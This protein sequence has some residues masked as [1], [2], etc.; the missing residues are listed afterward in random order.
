MKK[1]ACLLIFLLFAGVQVV[2]AQTTR[3]GTGIAPL[4]ILDG[5]EVDISTFDLINVSDI[6]SITALKHQTAIFTY[7]KCATH[8]AIVITT[9]KKNDTLDTLPLLRDVIFVLDGVV[10]NRETLLALNSDDLAVV[11]MIGRPGHFPFVIFSVI[12]I[13]DEYG[14]LGVAVVEAGEKTRNV[15]DI[16]KNTFLRE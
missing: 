6:K 16:I 3:I 4:F 12:S 10:T 13:Y 9:K 2:C 5:V 8:G 15:I 11:G 1:V 7:G 14:P